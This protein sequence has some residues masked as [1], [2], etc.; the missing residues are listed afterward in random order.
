ME[1]LE[2][3]VVFR[4]ANI[5]ETFPPD[6]Q[7]LHVAHLELSERDKAQ[8]PPRLSVFDCFKTSISEAQAIRGVS[9]ESVAFCLR[10]DDIRA[11]SLPE[12]EP[13]KVW[14]DPLEP[15]ADEMPGAGG[16]CG[17]TGLFRKP[18]TNKLLYKEIRV[19]LADKSFRYNH[20]ADSKPLAVPGPSTASEPD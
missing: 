13:L 8:K 18:G 15:P 16:H 5:K 4:L 20:P 2:E 9:A 1:E 11:A 10:V 17:I 7:K 3:G 19:H 12:L 6:S 14:R